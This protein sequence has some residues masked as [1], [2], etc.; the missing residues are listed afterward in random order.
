[1]A[2]ALNPFLMFP[3][4]LTPQAEEALTFYVGLFPGARIESVQRWDANGPGGPDRAGSVMLARAVLAG[5]TVFAS[6]SPVAHP[7]GFTPSLSLY[8]RCDDE[9]ELRRVAAALEEG[10]HALMPVGNYGF[11]RLFG[12]VQ[13]RFGVSWQLTLE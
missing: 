13:D 1:M 2:Q 12:W 8:V 10:G 3:G 5:Q 9:A 11:S 7:F 4:G 6:D